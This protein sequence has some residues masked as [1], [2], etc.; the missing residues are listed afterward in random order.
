VLHATKECYFAR[1]SVY[2]DQNHPD[3]IKSQWIVSKDVSIEHLLNVF[4]T[5]DA[6]SD[7]VWSACAD[8]MTHLFWH[9]KR[10]IILKPGSRMIITPSRNACLS[11]HGCFILLEIRWSAGG[12]LLTPWSSGGSG[13]TT[14]RLLEY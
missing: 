11:S 6:N 9:K 8:F 1:M 7:G 3:F 4:T 14:T 10:L 12:F 5:I 13:R 2:L